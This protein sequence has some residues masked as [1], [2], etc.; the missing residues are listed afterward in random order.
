MLKFRG[1]RRILGTKPS[2]KAK[3]T[4][5]YKFCSLGISKMAPKLNREELPMDPEQDSQEVLCN[6]LQ[7]TQGRTQA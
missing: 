2:H 5:G 1:W 4:T 7:E 3:K 6:R